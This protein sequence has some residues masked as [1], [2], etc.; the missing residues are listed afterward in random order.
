LR[1]KRRESEALFRS[2]RA[3][4][5][6]RTDRLNELQ[7]HRAELQRE[8]LAAVTAAQAKQDEADEAEAKVTQ[9]Q[10]PYSIMN[11][12][13]WLLDH[14]P[15]ILTILVTMFVLRWVVRLSSYRIVSL[16]TR[17]ARGSRQERDDRARTLAGVFHN[18]AS[19]TIIL[20]SALM[21][22]EEIGIAVGP[23]M[24]GAAVIGLA[25]AFGA[26]NL[27]RDYFYGFVIL[28]ENRRQ[29]RRRPRYPR[30]PSR[31]RC[32]WC[33]SRPR[34][35][36]RRV[37]R[38]H[39][40]RR[41]RARPRPRRR[42]GPQCPRRPAATR[43]TTCRRPRA[44]ARPAPHRSRSHAR[45]GRSLQLLSARVWW[46]ACAPIIEPGPDQSTACSAARPATITCSSL[47]LTSG[48]RSPRSL[49]RPSIEPSRSD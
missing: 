33:L 5:V 48:G 16:V 28:L 47:R 4:V 46:R 23:L 29:D 39:R 21:I 11:V 42:R 34:C 2:A 18:A 25:V 1:R 38:R 12:L 35:R 44:R 24:G 43:P 10:N 8:E 27:I 40:C 14:G 9:L 45:D 7:T 37:R 30:C 6:E 15:K 31:P 49:R 26:Q 3:E 13:Q 32:R 36:Y 20:G 17:G 22:C 41:H 19:V